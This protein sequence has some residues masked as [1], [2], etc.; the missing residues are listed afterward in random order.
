MLLILLSNTTLLFVSWLITLY[1]CPIVTTYK[2]V[3]AILVLPINP[4][5]IAVVSVILGGILLISYFFLLP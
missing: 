1:S 3:L 5:V 2:S 4:K